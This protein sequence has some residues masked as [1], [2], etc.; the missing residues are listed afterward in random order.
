MEETTKA[1]TWLSDLALIF[2]I[3][4]T[5]HMRFLNMDTKGWVPCL[6]SWAL[7]LKSM[8]QHWLVSKRAKHSINRP[9]AYMQYLFINF[10]DETWLSWWEY[11]VNIFKLLICEHLVCFSCNLREKTWGFCPKREILEALRECVRLGP[12]PWDS[13]SMREGW[14]VCVI[15][16]RHEL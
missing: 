3:A 1:L 11:K 7:C 13:R 16:C 14:Q 6:L 9:F 5:N 2:A 8:Y 4:Y 15:S 10:Y 12:K